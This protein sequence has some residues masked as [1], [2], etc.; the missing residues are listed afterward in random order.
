MNRTKTIIATIVI[1][2][3]VGLISYYFDNP[4]VQKITIRV[5]HNLVNWISN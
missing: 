2:M 4:V 3:I 5:N 1:M